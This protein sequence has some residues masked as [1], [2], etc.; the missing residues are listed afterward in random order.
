[1]PSLWL[2]VGELQWHLQASCKNKRNSENERPSFT[3]GDLEALF[4]LPIWTGAAT[5]TNDGSAASEIFHDARYWVP[6]IGAY[7]GARRE[8]ICGFRLDEIID[9]EGI[10]GFKFIPSEGR[11]FKSKV[12]VVI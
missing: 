2:F 12:S 5:G 10:W 1:M 7:Q 4:S 3:T 9:L 6:L 8:E 11:R